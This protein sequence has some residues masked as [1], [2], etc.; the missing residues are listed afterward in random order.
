[1]VMAIQVKIDDEALSRMF[2]RI[3]LLESSNLRTKKDDDRAMVNN[4]IKIIKEELDK[5]GEK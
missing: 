2:Q 3:R 5:A 4:I 1:M